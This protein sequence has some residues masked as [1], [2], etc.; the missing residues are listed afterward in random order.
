MVDMEKSSWSGEGKYDNIELNGNEGGR[1]MEIE[2]LWQQLIYE[3]QGFVASGR[4]E[5]I[6]LL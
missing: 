4:Y 1:Y 2:L 6:E 3:N 5:E